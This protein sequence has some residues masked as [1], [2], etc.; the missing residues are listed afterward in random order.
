[1]STNGSRHSATPRARG[2]TSEEA[3]TL[4][5]REVRLALRI[6]GKQFI[7]KY[8]VGEYNKSSRNDIAHLAA[9]IP[10]AR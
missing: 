3:R 4:F 8:K 7:Q 1:M 10:L 9:L 5:E 6:T 2:L